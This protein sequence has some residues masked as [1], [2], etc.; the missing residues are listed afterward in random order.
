MQSQPWD[1]KNLVAWQVAMDLAEGHGRTSKRDYSR[2]VTIARGSLKELETQVL[3]A[4]RLGFMG[5]SEAEPVLE[6]ATRVNRLLTGLR[7]RLE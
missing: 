2:F 4:E 5:K 6:L 3:L 1:L 7:K